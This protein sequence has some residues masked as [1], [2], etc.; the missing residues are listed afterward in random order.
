MNSQALKIISIIAVVTLLSFWFWVA[1]EPWVHSET[2]FRDSSLWILP[3]IILVVLAAST[4]VA[5][6]LLPQ[7]R[8][9]MLLAGLIAVT[10]VVVFG[11]G[12]PQI[13]ALFV[14]LILHV[15]AI[16]DIHLE[17]RERLKIHPGF[18][19]RRGIAAIMIPLYIALSF[20]YFASPSI[21]ENVRTQQTA[22]TF[23]QAVQNYVIEQ[24]YDQIMR[25]LAPYRA[26]FPPVLAFGLFLVLW[27]L[28]FVFHRVAA[29]LGMLI[30]WLLRKANF[31]AIQEMD[32]KAESMVL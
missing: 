7:K 12:Y 22:P 25:Q 14:I 11:F 28:G 20:A 30:F 13:L 3:A 27:G 18:I 8:L 16:R 21:H 23:K 32:V 19:I 17:S 10:Y 2:K 26:Y 15:L 31:V 1:A 4:A 24:A 5:Y 6:M 29:W 9:K